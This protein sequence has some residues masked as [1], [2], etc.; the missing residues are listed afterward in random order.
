MLDSARAS[1]WENKDALIA[2]SAANL[3][4]VEIWLEEKSVDIIRQ[5][6][7]EALNIAESISRIHTIA[8]CHRGYGLLEQRSAQNEPSL[9]KKEI[10][11]KDAK[12]WLE[13]NF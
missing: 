11:L 10:K 8:W 6:F 5:R 2:F 7:E 12:K 4:H 9:Q 13:K 3:G 1:Q